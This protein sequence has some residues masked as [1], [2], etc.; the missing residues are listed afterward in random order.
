MDPA[1]IMAIAEAYNKYLNDQDEKAWKE[2]VEARLDEIDAKL[3]EALEILRRLDVWMGV[4]S[5]KV[6]D[7]PHQVLRNQL[8]GSR[9]VL[10]RYV[11][12]SSDTERDLAMSALGSINIE[13][14]AFFNTW[15]TYGFAYY[16][17]LYCGLV[18]TLFAGAALGVSR[19]KIATL[20]ADAVSKYFSSALSPDEPKSLE[21][22]R[23]RWGER[24]AA[25]HSVIQSRLGRW[26]TVAYTPGTLPKLGGEKR[27]DKP[28]G[29]DSY[30]AVRFSETSAGITWET[31]RGSAGHHAGSPFDPYP[32]MADPNHTVGGGEAGPNDAGSDMVI[33]W[34]AWRASLASEQKLAESIANVRTIIDFL[35]SEVAAPSVFSDVP[36]AV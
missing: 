29:P 23:L 19:A 4:I 12:P 27:P 13:I 26:Y 28:G 16:Q 3:N 1:T 11:P 2:S 6:D 33:R 20:A 10:R 5:E 32:D 21:Y 9:G 7:I 24:A 30:I 15:R 22:P 18:T 35:S 25:Q 17:A 31:V 36:E 8:V 34:N 14:E